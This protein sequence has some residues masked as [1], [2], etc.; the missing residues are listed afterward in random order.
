[1]SRAAVVHALLAGAT[2]AVYGQVVGFDFV[3]YDDPHYVTENAHVRAGLTPEGVRWAF[4]AV[5]HGNWHPL[6]GLS[7]MLDV[8]LYGLSPGGH[9]LTSIVFHVLNA[10]LLGAVLQS[11]TGAVY[12]SAVVA[13]LFALHPLH[14][15]SVAWV[16]ERK[17]VLSTFFGFLSMAAYVAYARRG[18]A[19]RYLLTALLFALSLMAKPMLVTLPLVFLLLDYWP[20]GRLGRRDGPHGEAVAR[21]ASRW[22]VDRGSVAPVVAEKLPLL[23]LTA[24]SSVVTMMVQEPTSTEVVPLR[25]RLANAAVSYVRYGWKTLWPVDLSVLYPH[26]NLAGGT[27]WAAWQVAGASI[28]LLAVTAAAARATA[29]YALVGWL[30]YLGTLVPVIGIVQVGPQ[31]MADRYTYVPIVG[32][33]I[34]VVWATA[35]LLRTVEELPRIPRRIV[36]ALAVGL[37]ATLAVRSWHQTRYWRSSVALLRHAVEVAPSAAVMHA[38]LGV[39]LDQQ[40]DADDAVFHYE[41]ALAIDPTLPAAHTNLGIILYARG[42]LDGALRHYRAALRVDDGSAKAHNNLAIVLHV[43]GA[44][45]EAIGHYRSALEISPDFAEAHNNLARALDARGRRDEAIQHYRQ[46]LRLRP[47]LASTHTH[48]ARALQAQGRDDEAVAHYREAVRLAPDDAVAHNNLGF[49]LHDRGQIEEAIVHYREAL[50]ARPDY[51]QAHNNLGLALHAQG[52]LAEA[53]AHYELALRSWPEY[54][55]AHTNLGITL[56]TQGRLD[57]AIAHY[58]RALELRPGYPP[59]QVNLDEALRQRDEAIRR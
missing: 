11:M 39:A 26:P 4:T 35:D 31:A 41:R 33:F 45:D 58:R 28:L 49:M 51:A 30:W 57:E 32:L 59:A 56:H 24:A 9:H 52:N 3:V 53:A 23:L 34:A 25:L 38:N 22:S 5:H 40:G 29:R 15:E 50:R 47:D 13:A 36:A 16:S 6:T 19:G 48:L 42:D 44:L 46:A 1:M 21:R 14:V 27:P 8:E 18:G 54:V 55:N 37:L 7:Y 20:L 43:Q 12:R 17:D 2:I 10:L